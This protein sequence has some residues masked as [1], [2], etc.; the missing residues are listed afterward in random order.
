MEAWAK[1]PGVLLWAAEPNPIRSRPRG[2]H[3]PRN[4]PYPRRRDE[5]AG[6]RIGREG[7]RGTRMSIITGRWRRPD[8][9][10]AASVRLPRRLLV[11]AA[12]LAAVLAGL[13]AGALEAREVTGRVSFSG[14]RGAQL[15]DPRHAVVYFQP[16]SPTSAPPLAPV[17]M[18]TQDKEFVPRV[19]AVTP[20]TEVRF[21]NEDPILHNVFSVSV[22]N[23]FDLGLYGKGKW[24]AHSFDGSGIVRIFCNV[25]HSMVGYVVV[26][27]TPYFVLADARGRFRLDVP[28]QAGQLVIW[29]PQ[30]RAW[31]TSLDTGPTDAFDVDLEVIRERIPT[32]LNKFGRSYRRGKRGR[33]N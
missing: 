8:G 22:E 30:A 2:A 31:F 21:P 25:H 1:A 17:V 24:K 26:L 29:H 15:A 28:D 3:R 7:E 32:H 5:A 4:A 23:T 14:K 9:R 19:L 11:T 33:Y 12:L 13:C 27:P 18:S 6:G 20:G 16:A 10:R